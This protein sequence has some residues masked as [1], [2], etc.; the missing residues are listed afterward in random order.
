MNPPCPT[1][2]KP[3]IPIVYGMPGSDL[4]AAGERGEIAFGGCVIGEVNPDWQCA[5]GHRWVDPGEV[6]EARTSN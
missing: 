5:E 1:C 4:M 3:G 6:T 2:D